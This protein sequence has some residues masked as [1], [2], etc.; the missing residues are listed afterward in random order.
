MF[1]ETKG[2]YIII[3]LSRLSESSK[4]PYSDTKK[5]QVCVVWSSKERQPKW[6]PLRHFQSQVTWNLTQKVTSSQ[7]GNDN[8]PS[9]DFSH[10]E[11]FTT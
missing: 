3:N 4:H 5:C 6:K 9:Q 11:I 2:V 7:D 8:R 1:L 10:Q